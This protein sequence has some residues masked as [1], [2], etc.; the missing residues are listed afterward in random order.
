MYLF[1]RL[2]YAKRRGGERFHLVAHSPIGSDSQGWARLKTEARSSICG[3]R[4]ISS[5]LDREVEQLGLEPQWAQGG[6]WGSLASVFAS[7]KWEHLGHVRSGQLTK[8]STHSPSTAH[9]QISPLWSL[10][11]SHR[12]PGGGKGGATTTG[13]ICGWPLH[14]FPGAT[15]RG[16]GRDGTAGHTT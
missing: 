5:E 13:R 7:V 12:V 8:V 1:E 11:R 6:S 3:F 14:L 10:S 15:A 16:H 9:R 4:G 2:S